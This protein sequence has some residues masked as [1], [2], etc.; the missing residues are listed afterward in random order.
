MRQVPHYLLIGNGRVARHFQHYFFLLNIP[1]LSWHRGEELSQLQMHLKSATHI[2]LLIS[3]KAIDAFIEQYLKNRAAFK[4]HFSGSLNSHYA[5]GL[6]PLMSFNQDLYELEDYQHIPFV[7]DQDAPEF[8]KLLPGLPNQH[9]RLD[10]V[11]KAKY[12]A[13]CVLA[14]NF[15]CLLWQKFMRTLQEFNLSPDFAKTFLRQSTKNLLENPATA[16]TGPLV[17]ND[18]NTINANLNALEGDPFK[19]VYRSFVE[20]YQRE[21]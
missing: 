2:L 21:K 5:Y 4:I 19:E 16:L 13:S 12:H 15:S 18:F 1:F 20:A 8:A 17:R 11:L 3:D 6:H 14:N 7:I 9:A 10:K